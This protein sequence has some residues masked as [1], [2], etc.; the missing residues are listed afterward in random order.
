MEWVSVFH[1]LHPRRLS[2]LQGTQQPSPLPILTTKPPPRPHYQTASSPS[3]PNRLPENIT[4]QVRVLMSRPIYSS[5]A[6]RGH[7][8]S[9]NSPARPGMAAALDPH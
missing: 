9:W 7:Y 2:K 4:V 6:F 1:V 8:C 5:P 3:L